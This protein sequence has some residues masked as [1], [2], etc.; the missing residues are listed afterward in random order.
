[1]SAKDYEELLYQATGLTVPG[2]PEAE[3]S[4]YLG[5][6]ESRD[7]VDAIDPVVERRLGKVRTALEAA[8]GLPQEHRDLIAKADFL[9]YAEYRAT[10]RRIM[11]L[12]RTLDRL[13]HQ[14]RRQNFDASYHPDKPHF[15]AEITPPN[16][17]QQA[18][19]RGYDIDRFTPDREGYLAYLQTFAPA[20]A[21]FFFK[22]LPALIR[23]AD[24]TMHT[25]VTGSSGSGKSE[26]MKVLIHSYVSRPKPPCIVVLDPH[27]KFADEVA[28]QKEVIA[29]DRLVYVNP[30]LEAGLTP[31]LN[32]FDLDTP[33]S[34]G[35][36]AA[37]LMGVFDE[38][39]RG[40]HHAGLTG[41]MGALL[42]P[43]L[44]AL[45]RMPETN[46]LTLQELFTCKRSDTLFKQALKHMA[47]QQRGFI[48]AE[49][50][51]KRYETTKDAIV[52]KIQS[53]MNSDAFLNFLCGKSTINLDQVINERKIICFSLQKGEI[54][55]ETVSAVGSFVM[56][57]LQGY[58][59]RKYKQRQ[60][61]MVPI[62]VFVDECHNFL[63]PAVTEILEE[64]R[65]FGL[66][67]TLAQQYAGQKMDSELAKTVL[68]NTA[69]KI[70]G[71]N[72]EKATHREM[73]RLMDID[74]SRLIAL[75]KQK[76]FVKSGDM[77]AIKLTPP[78]NLADRRNCVSSKE[79]KE[80]LKRQKERYYR[81]I[82]TPKDFGDG[83]DSD[84]GA[85]DD[86]DPPPHPDLKLI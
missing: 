5:D 77:S 13:D 25:Y 39:F 34:A 53:L 37:Q 78:S 19:I 26:L 58:V 57:T 61:D 62:H 27:G 15:Y 11:D 42:I 6:W 83:P 85:G 81:P 7:C 47:P 67:L 38:L 4:H 18:L 48:S 40:A 22:R 31:V 45:L 44:T 29:D 20:V 82:H 50:E 28:A 74:D 43:C 64:A 52:G 10:V 71:F 75:Q 3:D 17:K 69:V 72:D 49:W 32:P 86:R 76:F 63:S 73:S 79:W 54:D 56:A 55:R 66:H 70:A 68:G 14:S 16:P 59:L 21:L 1:M 33:K 46:L 2:S 60:H 8:E 35:T 30:A 12:S 24:R 36:V 9:S 23:E 84:A 80:E 41:N 51:K 65:K